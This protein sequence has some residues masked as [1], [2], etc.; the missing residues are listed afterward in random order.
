MSVDP[1]ASATETAAAIREGR[2]SSVEALDEM[3]ARIARHNPALNAICTLDEA[4]ARK[5]AAQ[6]DSQRARGDLQGPLHGVPIT[7]KD[8]IETANLRTTGGF[9]PLAQNIP[10]RDA[11]VVAR[12]RAAGA[13]IVGKTNVPPLSADFRADNPIFGRT[14]NPW[15]LDCTPGGS[16]GGGAVAIAAGLS[17][18]EIG[19]DIAGSIRIPAHYCG[20]YG[21]KPTEHRVPGTGHIPELPGVARGIRHMSC[22]GPLARSVEDLALALRLIAGPDGIDIQTAPVPLGEVVSR[23]L[24]GA[25]IAWMHDFAGLPLSRDTRVSLESLVGQLSD[26]GCIVEQRAPANFDW[27]QAW[28]T[29]GEILLAERASTEPER[30]AQRVADIGARLDSENPIFRGF[31]RGA[32]ASMADYTR[33]L[34]SRDRLIMALENFL[35]DWDALLC[36]VALCPAVG[37]VPFG[38]P[39][40][41]DGRQVNYWSAGLALTTP[42]SLTGNPVVVLPL[43]RSAG[44]LPIGV[45]L[46]GRRWG[47]MG[48]LALAASVAQLTGPFTPPP[49]FRSGGT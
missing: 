37:H 19:S 31:A 45:Q 28:E 14:N 17:F 13:V 23:P 11:P 6:A 21:L 2:F 4:G 30:A 9:P 3:L 47:E 44:G 22:I 20:V 10:E 35:G 1:F 38:T 42:F 25:R 15:N 36:P 5:R 18:L 41:V 32:R 12:L 34:S 48:L 43:A 26:A 8:A 46:V 24:R 49:G 7:I 16:T 39:I 27:V 33:S 40:E 29:W